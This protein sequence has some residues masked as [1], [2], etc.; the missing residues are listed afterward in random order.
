MTES[1]IILFFLWLY[2]TRISSSRGLLNI[3]FGR[4]GCWGTVFP[5]WTKGNGAFF[6]FCV[7]Q[8]HKSSRWNFPVERRRLSLSKHQKVSV[9]VS[10]LSL[11]L[12]TFLWIWNSSICYY[13]LMWGTPQQHPSLPSLTQCTQALTYELRASHFQ[14]MDLKWAAQDQELLLN[15][16]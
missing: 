2:L 11:D 16:L 1:S 14:Q 7:R 10:S 6:K 8:P 15:E 4:V 9:Q 5:L 12:C 3:S 13:F